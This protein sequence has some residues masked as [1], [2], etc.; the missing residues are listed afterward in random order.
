MSIAR[1]NNGK[2]AFTLF[3]IILAVSILAIM[4]LAIYRFVQSN[5]V[6]LRVSSE[7]YASDAAY[8]GLKEMLTAQ[9]QALPSGSGSMTGDA[10][11]IN[12][13]SRDE[14]T[15]TCSSGPGLR[16]VPPS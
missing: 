7:I 14:V 2:R 6:A 4:S 9:W 3:E 12:D 16:Q 15:W 13:L 10:V 11:T 5:L 1:A 8:D